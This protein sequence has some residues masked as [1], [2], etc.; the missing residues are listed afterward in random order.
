L[1]D[2]LSIGM[3]CSPRGD[4]VTAVLVNRRPRT[5]DLLHAS[6]ATYP[7][8]I[9]Q[10]LRQLVEEGRHLDDNLSCLLDD[11]LGRFC[12]RVAQDLVREAGME[13]RD[14]LVIGFEGQEIIQ[15]G[16]QEPV[17]TRLGNGKILAKNTSTAVVTHFHPVHAATQS[18]VTPL[19]PLFHRQLFSAGDENRAVLTIS[20]TTSLTLLPVDG[21]FSARLC[22]YGT[23]LLDT[24]AARNLNQD[25]DRNG[26]WAG[27]GGIDPDLLERLLNDRRFGF[28]ATEYPMPGHR[29]L[30]ALE[31]IL[32]PLFIKPVDV[33][34]TLT[35]L[36]ATQA[37]RPLLSG[38]IPDRLLVSGEGARNTHLLRRIAALLP[39][40]VVETSARFGAEPLWVD[41]MSLA[42]LAEQRL[43][44]NTHDIQSLTGLDQPRLLGEIFLPPDVKI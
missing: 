25:P 4:G 16:E 23:R 26:E 10:T 31:Q 3:R 34:A 39:D 42:W 36:I 37:S 15:A 11:N 19:T 27:K 5:M 33:Q 2:S 1:I 21:M 13:M 20:D 7:A 35:E 18:S 24:W 28:E 22:G 12:A 14:I 9:R 17:G 43:A 44:E 29:L 6:I 30:E 40:S 38:Q 41:C 8:A 32:E